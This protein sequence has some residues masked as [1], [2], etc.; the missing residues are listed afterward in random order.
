MSLVPLHRE[1]QSAAQAESSWPGS[2]PP[3]YR[4][5]PRARQEAHPGTS[6]IVSADSPVVA[7]CRDCAAQG[8][9]SSG[10]HRTVG[11][12]KKQTVEGGLVVLPTVL[13][14]L[15]RR[16]RRFEARFAVFWERGSPS[17]RQLGG[18]LCSHYREAIR[19]E[20]PPADASESG[21]GWSFLG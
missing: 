5:W 7:R 1:S 18:R 9:L 11:S 3:Y 2:G 14:R 20:I 13:P 21:L 15:G 12:A 17:R 6:A 16:T 8:L 19:R 10:R 4:A